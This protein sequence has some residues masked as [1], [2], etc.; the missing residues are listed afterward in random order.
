[1][2]DLVRLRSRF[3]KSDRVKIAPSKLKDGAFRQSVARTVFLEAD[4][5]AD[6]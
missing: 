3:L 2:V 5:V 6:L 4:L 1:M